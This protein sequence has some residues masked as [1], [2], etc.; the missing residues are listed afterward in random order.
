MRRRWRQCLGALRMGTCRVNARFDWFYGALAVSHL[1]R[2][3]EHLRRGH[4]FV[5]NAIRFRSKVIARKSNFG[6]LENADSRAPAGG[7]VQAMKTA[8]LPALKFC[9]LLFLLPGLAGLII[10]ALIST[11]YLGSMPKWPV[12]EEGR[13]VAREIHGTTV[14]QTEH[15]NRELDLIEYSSVGVFLIG[16]VL[17]VVYLEMWGAAQSR[18]AEEGSEFAENPR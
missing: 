18:A 10:S 3:F 7:E 11:H 12:P 6:I 4:V 8:R 16:L 17:G 15:E 13:V 14:Y 5:R 9:A 2:P 1:P